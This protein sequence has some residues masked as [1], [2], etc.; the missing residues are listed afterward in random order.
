MRKTIFTLALVLV[1][2][3]SYPNSSVRTVDSRPALAVANASSTALLLIDGVQVG[4]A[5]SYDGKK[6][7]L[8]L[9]RGTHKVTVQDMGRV[10]FETTIYLGDDVTK[11][12]TVP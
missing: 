4:L 7:T 9:D 3:C 2:G 10:V 12:I 8:Q 11:T 5:S 1:A 6:Q